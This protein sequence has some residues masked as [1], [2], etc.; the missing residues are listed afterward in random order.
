MAVDKQEAVLAAALELFSRHTFAGTPV[1]LIAATARVG[2]GTIYR[3]FADKEDVGNAV[4][5]R[6]QSELRGRL[7]DLPTTA[8]SREQLAHWWGAVTGYALDRPAAFSFLFHQHHDDYL[9]ERSRLLGEEVDGILLA[10][11]RRGQRRGELR[12]ADARLQAALLTG[13]AAGLARAVA[14]DAVRPTRRVLADAETAAWLLVA[15]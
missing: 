12:K 15:A 4:Y 5:R 10:L 9:D 11:V 2:A 6:C 8:A 3:Y 14:T 13:A 1:P 7:T